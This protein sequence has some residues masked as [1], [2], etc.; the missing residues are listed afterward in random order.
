[1][2]RAPETGNLRQRVAIEAAR[3]MAEQGIDDYLSAKKKA[4]E[5]LGLSDRAALPANSEVELALLEH[6]RLFMAGESA[7]TLTSLRTV[8]LAAMQF[9]HKFSPRLVGSVLSG[10]ITTVSAV[11]L[12][13]FSDS[14][15]SVALQLIDQ[16]I[17]Y[18]LTERRV[19]YRADHYQGTPVFCFEYADCD[20]EAVVF[21]LNGERQPPLSPVNGKPM[22]RMGVKGV[23]EL[24]DVKQSESLVDRFFA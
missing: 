3:L 15:E 10:A 19:R 18:R 22:Q 17:D 5:R 2:A 7:Q 23:E 1:M 11:E 13:L 24:L 20:I 14:S 6:R 8:A 12:H 4:A 21:P 9:L 16:Q